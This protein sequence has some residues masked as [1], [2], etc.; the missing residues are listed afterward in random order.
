MVRILPG[1][2]HTRVGTGAN[3]AMCA[4]H[5]YLY[6]KFREEERSDARNDADFYR[7]NAYA[8]PRQQAMPYAPQPR[9]R[10]TPDQ[11]ARGQLFYGS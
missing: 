1:R 2:R 10:A 4:A 7:Q 11:M 3:R 8:Q 6:T 5:R 9:T